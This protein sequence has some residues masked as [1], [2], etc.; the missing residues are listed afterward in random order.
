MPCVG[1]GTAAG[2]GETAVS[3]MVDFFLVLMLPGAGDELQGI[4]KGVLELADGI[5]VNKCDADNAPR[6][7]RRGR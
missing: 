1:A 3:E 4:K 7:R 6:A 5:A 2:C